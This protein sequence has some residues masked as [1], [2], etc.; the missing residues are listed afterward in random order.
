MRLR[1]NILARIALDSPAA[2]MASLDA[3]RIEGAPV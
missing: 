1:G 3:V 2:P